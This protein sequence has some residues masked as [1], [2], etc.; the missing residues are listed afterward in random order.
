MNAQRECGA[1]ATSRQVVLHPQPFAQYFATSSRACLWSCLADI[2]AMKTLFISSCHLCC[3]KKRAQKNSTP[4]LSQKCQQNG[5]IDYLQPVSANTV[6]SWSSIQPTVCH[7]FLILILALFFLTL[8][9]YLDTTSVSA[10]VQN[11]TVVEPNKT[12]G[13]FS[14]VYIHRHYFPFVPWLLICLCKLD[15]TWSCIKKKFCPEFWKGNWNIHNKKREEKNK[16][17]VH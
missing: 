14:C 1:T 4:L 3:C 17:Q 8:L 6:Q 5:H 13:V 9:V 12:K 11:T 16:I 10:S 2:S 15:Y 7:H